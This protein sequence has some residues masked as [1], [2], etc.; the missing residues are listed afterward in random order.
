[1]IAC[2]SD[3]HCSSLLEGGVRGEVLRGVRKKLKPLRKQGPI[4]HALFLGCMRVM[5]ACFR[6]HNSVLLNVHTPHQVFLSLARAAKTIYS[7]LQGEREKI[8]C[9][10][11][12]D[13]NA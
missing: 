6:R 9:M 7:L 13:T 8:L 12:R 10:P 11:H 4:T 3:D 5:G 2:R 1:M